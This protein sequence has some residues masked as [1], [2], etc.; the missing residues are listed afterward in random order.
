MNDRMDD[1]LRDY[2][3]RWRAD[4]APPP[5]AYAMAHRAATGAVRYPRW[6]PAIAVAAAVLLVLVGLGV[7]RGRFM[8]QPAPATSPTPTVS[9]GVVPFVAL[10]PTGAQ[11]PTTVTTPDPDPSAAVA[12]PAC[13]ASDLTATI[14][15]EG[16][17]GT[18]YVAVTFTAPHTT[19]KLEGSPTVTPLDAN[20]RKAAVPV[21][22][23]AVRGDPY[24]GP[25]AVSAT[26]PALL[27]IGWSAAHWCGSV[28]TVAKLRIDIPGGGSVTVNG[29]GKS[30]CGDDPAQTVQPP[31]SVP[32]FTPP[33][34]QAAHTVTAFHGVAAAMEAP[35]SV[36]A[37]STLQLVISLTVPPGPGVSL[38]VCPDYDLYFGEHSATYALNCA[39]V[40]SRDEQGRPFLPGGSTTRFEATV[41]APEI[42]GEYK[43]GW[44]LHAG[45]DGV[46]TAT[47]IR[48][49]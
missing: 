36:A 16:A 7:A 31:I 45:D 11:L 24:D 44:L 37:G 4:Q 26:V 39:A 35:Q 14:Q 1:R 2:A 29:F 6:V 20:G 46:A 12:L 18:L 19:C 5:S 48:V 49:E 17:T 3:S 22:Q 10:P 41:V 8:L 15:M 30:Y 21:T 38:A 28:V 34:Y 33:E 9:P 43:M 13:R 27:S 42:A 32:T 47:Q 25:V 23:N 40:P